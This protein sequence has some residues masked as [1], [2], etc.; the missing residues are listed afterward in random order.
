MDTCEWGWKREGSQF[1]PTES[2]MNTAPDSFLKTI[3]CNCTT[4]CSTPRCSCRQNNLPCTSACGQCQSDVCDNPHDRSILDE[5][6][7]RIKQLIA[8]KWCVVFI[9]LNV[10]VKGSAHLIVMVF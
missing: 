7:E 8:N 1:V 5:E 9:L 6:R 3:H 10:F 4:A 2:D